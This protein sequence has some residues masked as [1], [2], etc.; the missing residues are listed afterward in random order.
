MFEAPAATSHRQSEREPAMQTTGRGNE[1]LML[2]VPIGV[3]VFFMVYTNG[4][5]ESVLETIDGALR[6]VF[7]AAGDAIAGWFS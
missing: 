4:G 5:V 7:A 6:G 3:I 1:G 2:L